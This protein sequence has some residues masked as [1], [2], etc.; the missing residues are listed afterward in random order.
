M[1]MKIWMMTGT[2]KLEEIDVEPT[3][4]DNGGGGGDDDGD[5]GSGGGGGEANVLH[6]RSFFVFVCVQD[7]YLFCLIS[8]HTF[9][10]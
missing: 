1:M 2:T 7:M 9:A 3:E 5:N 4:D 6:V 10:H 8:L